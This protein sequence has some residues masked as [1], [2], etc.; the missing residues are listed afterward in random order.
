MVQR[1]ERHTLIY[2]S[3]TPYLVN[4]TDDTSVAVWAVR[5]LMCS[6][7]PR[8]QRMHLFPA[9]KHRLHCTAVTHLHEMQ[10]WKKAAIER[11]DTRAAAG[12]CAQ[13]ERRNPNVIKQ[14]SYQ[15]ESVTN[16]VT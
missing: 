5:D 16:E 12:Q 7:L 10:F 3:T 4:L 1:L 14:L 6:S 15:Y 13:Y 11:E 9:F 8:K 2:N